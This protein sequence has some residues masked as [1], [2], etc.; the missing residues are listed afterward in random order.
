[1]NQRLIKVREQQKMIEQKY[2]GSNAAL[3]THDY[4]A[5]EN[6]NDEER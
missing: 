6:L 1:M 4:T 5:L 2:A 3:S